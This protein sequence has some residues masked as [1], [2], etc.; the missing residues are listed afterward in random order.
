MLGFK[1][2]YIGR[3]RF[4]NGIDIIADKTWK[5]VVADVKRVGDTIIA[6]K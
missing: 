1:L 5:K 2:W 4:R 6:L 3:T